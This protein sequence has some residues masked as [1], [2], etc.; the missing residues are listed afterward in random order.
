M[1]NKND[2]GFPRSSWCSIA[3]YKNHNTFK[4]LIGISPDG[5]ITFVSDL[6]EG[7]ISDRAL[8]EVSCI[9]SML[10]ENESVMVDK[11]F[12]IQDL[13][14]SVKVR[15]NIHAATCKPSLQLGRQQV[16]QLPPA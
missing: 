5:C 4:S 10:D 9:V 2:L 12:E 15:L 11:G 13:F 3:D 8:T 14:A 1:K 16:F 7:S 6:Y